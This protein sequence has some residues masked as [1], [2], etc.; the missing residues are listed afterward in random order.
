MEML[1]QVSK[2]CLAFGILTRCLDRQ[3]SIS[4]HVTPTAPATDNTR[5]HC[6]LARNML[7]LTCGDSTIQHLRAKCVAHTH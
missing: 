2:V 7:I 5:L 6:A 3:R 1:S 4:S